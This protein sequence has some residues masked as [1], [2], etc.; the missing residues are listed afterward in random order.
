MALEAILFKRISGETISG[1]LLETLNSYDVVL[2]TPPAGVC[3]AW[4]VELGEGVDSDGDQRHPN[5]PNR[6]DQRREVSRC[7]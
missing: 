7:S 3:Y 6:D 2:S 1:S 4:R 5:R